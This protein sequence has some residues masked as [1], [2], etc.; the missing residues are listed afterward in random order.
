MGQYATTSSIAAKLPGFLR[1]DSLDQDPAAAALFSTTIDRAEAEINSRLAAVYSLPFSPVPPLLRELAFEM[2]AYYA[3]LALGTR[4][5]PNK[6]ES[7]EAYARSFTVLDEIVGKSKETPVRELVNTDGSI[8]GRNTN[9][10]VSSTQNY[11]PIFGMDDPKSWGVDSDLD[12]DLSA[13]RL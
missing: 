12:D 11:T 10:I 7:I 4:D 8:V 9:L 2:G 1:D 5:W 13:A 3:F 6:N